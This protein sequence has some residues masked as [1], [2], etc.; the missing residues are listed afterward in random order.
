M[1]HAKL[2][3]RLIF[4]DILALLRFLLH[5]IVYSPHAAM[6]SAVSRPG[7]GDYLTVD[8]DNIQ[9]CGTRGVIDAVTPLF[10]LVPNALLDAR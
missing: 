3:K 6:S 10:L 1:F 9:W 8:P 4:F 7:A 5:Q 2:E